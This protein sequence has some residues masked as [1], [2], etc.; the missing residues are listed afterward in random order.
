VKLGRRLAALGVAVGLA[1]FVPAVVTAHPLGNFTINHYAG[2]RISADRIALDVVI[3]QAEIPTFQ[4]STRIDADGDGTLSAAEIEAERLA[5]CPRLAGDLSLTVAGAA[6]PL[7]V[8]A[9]GLSFPPGAGGAS[10]MRIVCEYSAVPPAPLAAGAAVEFQDRSWSDRI[11]WREIVVQGDGTTIVGGLPTSSVSARLTTYPTSLLSSPLNVREATIQVTGSGPVLPAWSAPDAHAMSAAPAGSAVTTPAA[12]AAVPGGV[13]NDISGLLGTSDLTPLVVVL[14]F[15]TAVALGAG[16]ALTPGHGKTIMAAYLVG[17]K[18]TL[19]HAVGLG[20][21]TAV[22]HTIGV[23]VLALLIAAAGAALPADRIYPILSAVS[24]LIVVGIGAWLVAAQVTRWLRAP[25]AN[26]LVGVPVAAVA[27]AS[28][29]SHDGVGPHVHEETR[30]LAYGGAHAAVI[31][32]PMPASIATA[33]MDA[34]VH[35][36]GWRV[37]SHVPPA[38]DARPLGWRSLFAL[39]LAGGLV[40]STNA[41]LILVA[42]VAA[43]RTAYGMLLVVAF[44]IGMATVLVGVGLAM[45]HASGLLTRTTRNGAVERALAFAPTVAALAVLTL[46]LYLTAQAI[47]GNTVL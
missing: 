25:R 19:R 26:A 20:M 10:T 14:S 11:G 37:H 40:P 18:G 2:L 33:P 28:A 42:T 4:E 21:A 15:G 8:D 36:H 34:G 1:L 3:D 27:G 12:P 47:A 41:L 46:G 23:F 38:N 7:T 9:A 17:T 39:G 30:A 43:G 44:G 29:H 45:V 16:H 32:E 24:G 6:D 5:V 22:S 31:G 13:A 35:R